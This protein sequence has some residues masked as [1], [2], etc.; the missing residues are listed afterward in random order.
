MVLFDACFLSVL[1]HPS[2]RI[3]PDPA[4]GDPPGLARERIEHLIDTLSD[5]NETILIPTPALAEL[6]IALGTGGSQAISSLHGEAVFRIV[7]FDERAAIELAL[8]SDVAPGE[9]KQKQQAGT[10]AKVKFDRQIVAIAKVNK[11]TVIYST[12]R[13]VLALAIKQGMRGLACHDLPVPPPKNL[14]LSFDEQNP[15]A[16]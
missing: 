5:D 8:M 16:K 13:D 11:A 3:P 6:L 2:P 9:K 12:D 15:E 7:D 4:T 1:Y 14:E 10:W